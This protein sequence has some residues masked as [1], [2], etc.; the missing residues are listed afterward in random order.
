MERA[1]NVKS[2]LESPPVL[3]APGWQ[4]VK[5]ILPKCQQALEIMRFQVLL[6]TITS[7]LMKMACK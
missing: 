7:L 6:D 1:D 4:F 3:Q 5:S 2:G